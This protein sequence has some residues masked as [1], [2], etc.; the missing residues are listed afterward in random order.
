MDGVGDL[1]AC[2]RG[3]SLRDRP[4]R[5]LVSRAEMA[6]TGPRHQHI[7][8][9]RR[10]L[11]EEHRAEA[12]LEASLSDVRVSRRSTPEQAGALR[13]AEVDVHV[14]AGVVDLLAVFR[15]QRVVGHAVAV[16]AE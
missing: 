16:E 13:I 15:A 3:P 1:A 4:D 11:D 12:R 2:R 5:D 14:V 7:P 8:H 10:H 9:V 6:L